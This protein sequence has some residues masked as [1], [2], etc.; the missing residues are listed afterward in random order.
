MNSKIGIGMITC[1]SEH[2]L[3]QTAHL[4]PNVDAFVIVN[5]GMPYSQS[6]YPSHAEIIQHDKNYA[7][8]KSKNDALHYL[9]SHGCTHLFIIEDDVIIK[10]EKV[11]EQYIHAS[12]TSGIKHFNYALQGPNNRKQNKELMFEEKN[13]WEKAVNFIAR[14]KIL[15]STPKGINPEDRIYLSETSAPDP[16]FLFQYENGLQLAFYKNC[17]GAF[18]YYHKDVIEKVGYMDE[19]FVNAWEH[20]HHTYKII[21]AGFHPPFWWF[22]D[23]ANVEL[24]LDNIEECMSQ[25]T[26]AR[27]PNWG[28]NVTQGEEYFMQLEGVTPGNIKDLGL[29]QVKKSL[30][31]FQKNN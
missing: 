4:I 10:S 11:F 13:F 12:Q 27:S 23:I 5:D 19:T 16:R 24:Y 8:A 22:A 6:S 9:V 20:V 17:V 28:A 1:N 25:S 3:L 7:V 31:E 29:E 2:K 18:S 30:T 21:Q 26:I 15:L 14:K